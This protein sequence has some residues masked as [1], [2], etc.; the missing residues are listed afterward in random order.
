[1][2]DKAL[3]EIYCLLKFA[4]LYECCFKVIL[5]GERTVNDRPTDSEMCFCLSNNANLTLK[6]F[7]EVPYNFSA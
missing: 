3:E 6:F 4:I 5:I 2:A 1:M 7:K